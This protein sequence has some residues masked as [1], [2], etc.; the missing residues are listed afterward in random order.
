MSGAGTPGKPIGSRDLEH[1]F[2]HTAGLWEPLR[3][4]RVFISG[5]TGFVGTWLLESFLH[6]NERLGLNARAHVLSRDPHAFLTKL[7]HLADRAALRFVQGEMGAFAFPRGRFACVIHGAT[8]QQADLDPLELFNRNI[9]G[10]RRLL[11]LARRTGAGR[12]LLASSGAVYGR[13]PPEVALVPEEYPGAPQ[14]TDPASAYGQSKRV[15]EFLCAAHA[16]RHGLVA[17]VARCFAFVGPHLPLD[18]NFAAGNFIRDA[19]AG[20]P[21]RVSGD[22]TPRRSYLYAAD[23]A[24]WLWTILLRG[25]SCRAYN[26]GAE[27]E[28]SI[29]E[30]ARTVAAELRP[31]AAVAVAES[32]APGR[33]AGRYVP[34]TRRAREE[35]GLTARITLAEGIRRTAAWLG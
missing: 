25:E 32:A 18:A 4:R 2:T 21:I 30:L 7:P 1:V 23:L 20:G 15:S 6:I 28:L 11:E 34:C 29:A 35:L 26:V 33:A 27:E 5:G 19:L 16:R 24:I 8:E 13:Q 9:A 22:G 12:F 10:T 31:A 17:P 3:G 14:P